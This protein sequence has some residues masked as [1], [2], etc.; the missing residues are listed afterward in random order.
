MVMKTLILVV[1]VFTLGACCKG[2]CEPTQG[3]LI[4]IRNLQAV[5]TDTVYMVRYKA[6][7]GFAERLDTVKRFNPVPA[8]S[9]S[10]STFMEE[11]DFTND[12]KVIIPAV[13]KEY[14]I[15]DFETVTER[16]SCTGDKYVRV[17]KFSLNNTVIESSSAILD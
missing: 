17:K 9:T 12:W 14:F 16:C 10:P 8:G 13:N 11:L 4:S 15:S 1:I 7:T 5:D 6:N 2:E 3:V